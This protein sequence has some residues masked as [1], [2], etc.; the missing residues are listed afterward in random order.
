M[1]SLAIASRRYGDSSRDQPS[2]ESQEYNEIGDKLHELVYDLWN[3]EAVLIGDRRIVL[4]SRTRLDCLQV[5]DFLC[6]FLL[7]KVLPRTRFKSWTD[8]EA[9][10]Y[11]Y[12]MTR[13]GNPIRGWYSFLSDCQYALQPLDIVDLINYKSWKAESEYPP[14]KS[15]YMRVRG[16]FDHGASGG[17]ANWFS[18]YSRL[19]MINLIS[20]K[21]LLI[22]LN[23]GNMLCWWDQVRSKAGTPFC[24]GFSRKYRTELARMTAILSCKP[25]TKVKPNRSLWQRDSW[26]GSAFPSTR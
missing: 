19:L 17:A 16:M 22:L 9:G 6:S 18:G 15:N 23:D 7:P 21:P 13:G 10:H 4:S 11:P 3:K 8:P 20:D 1:H 24:S 26:L 25:L 12:D 14:D 5:F 2:Y